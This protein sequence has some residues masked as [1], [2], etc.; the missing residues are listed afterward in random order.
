MDA[1]DSDV[2][3]FLTTVINY[4]VVTA[5][6]RVFPFI[7][8]VASVMMTCHFAEYEDICDASYAVTVCTYEADPEVRNCL[9]VRINANGE[10][11]I[12][13]E[14]V[15]LADRLIE[16]FCATPPESLGKIPTS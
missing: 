9:Q 8:T 15:S 10:A 5:S 7:C 13:S 11:W 14:T 4:P 3:P 6:H 12:Y 1:K 2:I 16:D